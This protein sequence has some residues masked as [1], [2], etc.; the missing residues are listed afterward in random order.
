MSPTLVIVGAYL[1]GSIPFGYLIVRAC[2]GADVR[3]IGSGGTG[4]TNVTRHAG[5]AVG[6]LTLLLDVCKGAVAIALAIWSQAVLPRE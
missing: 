2:S 3:E 6:L 1:L 5:K 4:A